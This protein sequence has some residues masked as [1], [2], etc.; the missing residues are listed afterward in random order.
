MFTDNKNMHYNALK[1]SSK[2]MCTKCALML[3]KPCFLI[4][5]TAI[6]SER[7]ATQRTEFKVLQVILY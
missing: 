1:N 3:A 7:I 2:I 5:N 4:V 6:K